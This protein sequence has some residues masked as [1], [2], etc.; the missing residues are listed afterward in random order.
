MKNSVPYTY[1]PKAELIIISVPVKFLD[2]TIMEMSKYYK[3]QHICIASK[4][5]IQDCC[6]FPYDIVRNILNTNKIGVISGGVFMIFPNHRHGIGYPVSTD[7]NVSGGGTS[8][9][10]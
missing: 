4:G 9:K 2:S 8:Q 7:D 6:L 5:I 3:E 1:A 10:A